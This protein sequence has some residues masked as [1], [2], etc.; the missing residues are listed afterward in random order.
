L[1]IFLPK[2]C[3]SIQSYFSTSS[4]RYAVERAST[5]VAAD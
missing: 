2:R 3:A 5:S 4:L 1:A